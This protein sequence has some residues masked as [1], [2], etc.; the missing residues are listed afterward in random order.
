MHVR[1]QVTR[2][3][4]RGNGSMRDHVILQGCSTPM[5]RWTCVS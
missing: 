2:A 5:A 3:K 1:G 4:E